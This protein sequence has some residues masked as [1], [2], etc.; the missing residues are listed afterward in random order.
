MGLDEEKPYVCPFPLNKYINKYINNT[1]HNPLS[2]YECFT[3]YY[4]N[5]ALIIIIQRKINIQTADISP[6]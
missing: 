3:H 6:K 1:D 4:D 5:A 2:V